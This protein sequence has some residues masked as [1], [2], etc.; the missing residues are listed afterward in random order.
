MATARGSKE[1]GIKR[2]KKFRG[3]D[4]YEILHGSRVYKLWY[5]FLLEA[6]EL[7]KE[8]KI[9][10]NYHKST[11]YIGKTPFGR[12][13]ADAMKSKGVLSGALIYGHDIKAGFK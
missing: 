13:W 12:Y 5:E 9:E 6:V 1:R 2:S 4:E 11:A 8:L 10:S 3:D 7:E